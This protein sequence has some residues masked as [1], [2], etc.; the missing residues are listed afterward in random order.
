MNPKKNWGE[1]VGLVETEWGVGVK[2]GSKKKDDR[3]RG[4]KSTLR[5]S[6]PLVCRRG[7]SKFTG[8]QKIHSDP[9]AQKNECEPDQPRGLIKGKNK[10][11]RKRQGECN[12]D[13]G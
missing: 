7:R 12:F 8:R 4:E 3:A 10:R 5:H 11:G 1:N 9:R 13:G 2:K 6:K